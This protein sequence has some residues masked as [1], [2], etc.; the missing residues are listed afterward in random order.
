MRRDKWKK[1]F[2]SGPFVLHTQKPSQYRNFA[3]RKYG[4]LNYA[5]WTMDGNYDTSQKLPNNFQRLPIQYKSK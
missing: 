2:W 3:A 4:L 5:I 1:S